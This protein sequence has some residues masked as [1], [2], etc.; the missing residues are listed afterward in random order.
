MISFK[1]S[2]KFSRQLTFKKALSIVH[3][4]ENP[5]II[6]IGCIR[7]VD[8]MGAGN[9]SEL[10]AYFVSKYG[11]TFIT[12]DNNSKNMD[13]CK[14]V[15]KKYEDK[16]GHIIYVVNDGIEFLGRTDYQADLLYLDS[17]DASP[18]D[19]HIM[20][21]SAQHH[22]DLFKTY[23]DKVKENSLIL[24]DDVYDVE[25]FRGKGAKLIPYLLGLEH[26]CL[27]EIISI[28]ISGTRK[29]RG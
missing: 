6:E 12:V 15:L 2:P 18:D 25:T 10:F 20:G 5:I 27:E 3:E 24:I 29:G 16:K 11:G 14:S 13:L 1:N 26:N 19:N 22:F 8:D 4:V 17:L 7:E 23:E 9:S 21:L 28:F